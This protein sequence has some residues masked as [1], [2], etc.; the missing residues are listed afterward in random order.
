MAQAP[1]KVINLLLHVSGILFLRDMTFTLRLTLIDMGSMY[2]SL[3]VSP[4]LKFTE[5]I[6]TLRPYGFCLVWTLTHHC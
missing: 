3:S 2:T 4:S 5:M 1:L 6:L